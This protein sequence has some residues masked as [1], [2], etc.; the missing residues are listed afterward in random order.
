MNDAEALYRVARIGHA[1]KDP[2]SAHLT[3]S[4]HRVASQHTVPGLK[5]KVQERPDAVEV[6]IRVEEGA[7]IGKPVHLCFGMLPE[8]GIQRILLS[9]E[10]GPGSRIEIYAHCVFPN[11]V[12]V[13]HLMEGVIRIGEGAE[14]T[15]RERHLHSPQGGVEVYPQARVE[16]A[17]GARFHTDFELLQG[18]VGLID[19][20]YS[21][22][23]GPESV[24][25]MLARISGSGD[26]AIRIREKAHLAG[27]EAR[28]VLTSRV[29][30]RE[31]AAAEVYNEMLATGARARGHVDC[32]EIIRDNGR[33]KAVPVVEVGHPTAHVTHEAAIGS[34]DSRQ[35]STLMARGLTE[36]EAVNLIL[37][38]LLS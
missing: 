1:I 8:S 23:G 34:V 24:L 30:V 16:L 18:R 38:G 32:K 25:E 21:A 26:D 37:E 2:E 10:A 9:V 22:T 31:R 13:K 19:I 6:A 28:G 36:E 7:R 20:D 33:A 5:V 17:R 4:H 35:L 15:Y 29:A 27:E 14:Y 12:R 3:L 11:A